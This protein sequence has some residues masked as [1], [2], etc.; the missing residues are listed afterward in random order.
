MTAPKKKAAHPSIAIR[1]AYEEPAPHD[2]YRVLVDRFW[3]RGRSKDALALDEWARDLAPDPALIHW[4]AHDP[5]RW[6]E[7]RARYRGEL[8][9]AAQRV[10]LREL[11]AAAGRRRIT[12]V[13]GA[14]SET[15]NQAVVLREALQAIA[16]EA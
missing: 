4:F 13:Y 8:A 7:F 5:A 10:R 6:E 14:R 2:G 9:G 12:L 1:R 16:S 15:E 3:P 11:L